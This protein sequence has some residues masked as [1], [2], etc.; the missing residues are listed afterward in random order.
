MLHFYMLGYLL[1]QSNLHFDWIRPIWMQQHQNLS[2]KITFTGK[3]VVS[4]KSIAGASALHALAS[5]ESCLFSFSFSI[6]FT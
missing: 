4:V 3:I 1:A 6:S 2:K 5:N